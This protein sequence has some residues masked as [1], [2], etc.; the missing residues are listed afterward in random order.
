MPNWTYNRIAVKGEKKN[1]D[2]FMSD[3]IRNEEGGLS[4]SSWLP[5]PETY[6]KY[7]TTNHP[8]GKGLKV[9]EKWWDGFGGHD[10]QIVTEELI[11]EFKKATAE[12]REKYGVVGWYDYNLATFGC[13]WDCE[14][15]VDYEGEDLSSPGE[16]RITLS[17]DTPWSA[18]EQWLRTIS[19]KYPELTFNLY[20]HYEE[21]FW[22][23][24]DFRN[25]RKAEIG[26]GEADW[27]D[28]EEEN[29]QDSE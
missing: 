17:T 13:K 11:E 9:G 19:A 16:D 22:E 4:L 3:A 21:G 28:E 6:R 10:D 14:V 23:E 18:P 26:S 20:A 7:D 12:Q 25:G 1:L 29:E 5:I 8:D 27:Y 2:K 15:E 24:M